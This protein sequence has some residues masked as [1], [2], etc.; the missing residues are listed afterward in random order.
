M[1]LTQA[2]ATA[3]L[4]NLGWRVRSTTE[5]KQCIRNFQAGW[6]L[7]AALAVD[8]IKGPATDAALLLSEK[9]RRS[10]LPTASAHFSFSEVACRCWGRYVDCQRIWQ[11]RAT[12]QM[13]EKYRAKSGRPL[14]VV[15]GCRCPGENRSVGGSIYSEHLRGYACDVQ[16]LYST[17]TVKSWLV[18]KGI[19][20]GRYSRRVKHI[21]MG[22]LGSISSPN[23]FVDG[24]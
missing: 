1:A 20:Y 14:S 22:K 17:G 13:M 16:A 18:A 10:G 23:V 11:R 5:Y 15:S 9:R 12:F 6:N 8:G 24:A 19:G 3:I 4:R 2:Q 7:G 21:D